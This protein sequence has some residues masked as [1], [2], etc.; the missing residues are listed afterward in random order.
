VG[1][2]RT[3]F[4]PEIIIPRGYRERLVGHFGFGKGPPT[5]AGRS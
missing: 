3:T 2:A 5:R 1:H 4:D